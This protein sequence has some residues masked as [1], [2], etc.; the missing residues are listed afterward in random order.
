[1]T[2][3][4]RIEPGMNNEEIANQV[5]ERLARLGVREFCIAAGARNAALISCLMASRGATVRSFA[6]ERSAGFFAVGRIMAGRRP[7]AVVTTSG[8]AAG[9]LLPAMMEAH[10]QGLPLVAVTADRPASFRG[11]GAPQAVEQPGIFGCYAGASLDVDGSAEV[12]WP[13]SL[14]NQPLHV[15]VCLEEATGTARRGIDFTAAGGHEISGAASAG[16][17]VAGILESWLEKREGLAVLAAG[18]HPSQ[19]DEAAEFLLSVN[20]PVIAEATSNLW[21]RRDLRPL[22]ARGGEAALQSLDPRSVLRLGSVPSWRWWRDLE[23]RPD[24]AVLN[25]CEAPFP[26]L[27]RKENVATAGWEAVAF[28]ARHCAMAASM[29]QA[30]TGSRLDS[31]LM[32]TPGSEPACIRRISEAVPPGARVFLG[33][34]LPVREWNL[35]AAMPEPGTAFFANRGANGI[36]GVV[37]SFLGMS[38]GHDG[39]SWL[40]IGDLSAVHDLGG[41]WILN[42][43]PRAG[44][45]IVV[46]NNGGGKI[47]SRV[48]SLRSLGPEARRVIENRHQLS[49]EPWA[50]MWGLG[51][52][53]REAAQ[54]LGEL[55]AGPVIIEVRPDE[56][57]TEEF[58]RRWDEAKPRVDRKN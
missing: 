23:Q 40:V 41:L 19:A 30:A 21:R 27:A 50:R 15:N 8:T 25:V 39:E 55:P 29:P 13:R 51:Y 28:R 57:G 37:S 22:L 3:Q 4:H 11:S 47:F 20:A 56:E 2:S 44:L 1:M 43:L 14:R 18:I 36:D 53:L 7:V 49:F 9:E 52:E 35:A 31:I 48:P 32:E 42:Q 12:Q 33:N 26:G 16:D 17:A 38:A 34:S 46:I 5:L 54:P 24:V 45:R 58:W 10:Y 6:D